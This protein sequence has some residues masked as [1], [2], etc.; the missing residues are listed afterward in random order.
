MATLTRDDYEKIAYLASLSIDSFDDSFVSKMDG[1]V[2]LLDDIASI[3]ISDAWSSEFHHMCSPASTYETTPDRF[4][5]F[6]NVPH[7]IHDNHIVIK[8]PIKS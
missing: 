3:E 5:F 1:V 7:P 8:S 2:W 4:D 6:L